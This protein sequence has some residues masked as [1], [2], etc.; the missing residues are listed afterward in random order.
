[1]RPPKLKRLYEAMEING[2]KVFVHWSVLLISAVILLFGA[3]SDPAVALAGLASRY[4]AI[5]LHECGHMVVAQRKDCA[6]WS[7]E[8]YP[9]WGI[10]RFNE[11]YSR[12]DHCVIAWG[13]VVVQLI[14][15]DT[16]RKN[17]NLVAKALAWREGSKRDRNLSVAVWLDVKT[18]FLCLC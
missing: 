11:P 9:V 13:G 15:A 12:F 17:A 14:V 4:G 1:M 2:V 16:H 7:I 18:A 10:T 5:L 8:L 6:V 3:I